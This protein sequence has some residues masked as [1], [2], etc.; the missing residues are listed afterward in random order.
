MKPPKPG[1]RHKAANSEPDPAKVPTKGEASTYADGFVGKPTAH[2]KEKYSHEKFSAAVLGFYRFAGGVRYGSKRVLRL[3]VT[4]FSPTDKEN[5]GKAVIVDLN[6]TG[7]GIGGK[8]RVLDL[9]RAA[10]AYLVGKEIKYFKDGDKKRAPSKIDYVEIEVVPDDT[11]LG[12]VKSDQTPD[13]RKNDGAGR[14][15][16]SVEVVAFVQAVVWPLDLELLPSPDLQCSG[17]LAARVTDAH[18]CPMVTGM[19]A[20]IGGPI[21]A[22]GCPHVRI[23]GMPAARVTDL[24]VCIGPL[25]TIVTGATGVLIGGLPAARVADATAH[26][27]KIVEG[28]PAVRISSS[29]G[30]GAPP[31]SESQLA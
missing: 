6:D 2:G 21:V 4:N 19:V 13:T 23:G 26:G 15:P 8:K 18:V 11:P 10:Y 5:Y 3:K 16:T 27:G 22:P 12:P 9:S 25:D 20:H 17:R 24:A 1:K 30:G 14:V 7:P 29:G 28:F 31:P